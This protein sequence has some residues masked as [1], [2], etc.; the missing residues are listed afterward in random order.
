MNYPYLPEHQMLHRNFVSVVKELHEAS[1][2][3]LAVFVA[4]KVSNAGLDWLKNHIRV[5]DHKYYDY[6]RDQGL[7]L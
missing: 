7:Q 3:G 5:A 1:H 4:V 2:K 6:M